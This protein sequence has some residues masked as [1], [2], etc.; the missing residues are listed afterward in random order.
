MHF[1]LTLSISDISFDAV[2]LRLD[3]RDFP[4]ASH[5]LRMIVGE[6]SF[7]ISNILRALKTCI[8]ACGRG[9]SRE[10]KD[11]GRVLAMGNS[12]SA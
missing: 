7:D 6:G 8:A 10:A 5:N 4:A 12:F 11:G 3:L 1:L 9:S 2:K